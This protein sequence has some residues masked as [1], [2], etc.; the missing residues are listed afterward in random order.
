MFY[1][2]FGKKIRG[3]T[4]LPRRLIDGERLWRSDKLNQVQPEQF[5]AEYANLLPLAL[6]DGTFECDPHRV[7]AQVYAYNR[8]SISARNVEE[9]LNEFERVKLLFRWQ[10]TDKKWWGFWT[11]IK[12]DGLL[13]PASQSQKYKKGKI[14]PEE[15]LNS[16]LS[17]EI[18]DNLDS[19]QT[20]GGLGKA[21]FGF[22]LDREGLG[23]EE[24]MSA[25]KDKIGQL[26]WEHLRV[27]VQPS[28]KSYPELL[29][30]ARII[31]G[32]DKL[33][34]AFE[35]FCQDH[36][37][38]SIAYPLGMFLK[39]LDGY[40]LSASVQTPDKGE[41]K[42]LVNEL[43][44]I[45]EGS[46]IAFDKK[47]QIALG[48]L[49]ETYRPEEI[50]GAFQEFYQ[51]VNDDFDKKHAARKFVETVEQILYTQRKRKEQARKTEETIRQATIQEQQKAE[52]ERREREEVEKEA[53]SL[54][55]DSLPS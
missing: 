18:E 43:A 9:I 6:A 50:R 40:V 54:I 16:F 41:A 38:E 14:P 19:I 31:G 25:F 33:I 27:M 53:E 52:N 29:A 1:S 3:A 30:R 35:T 10:E 42:N 20:S 8:P 4:P 32:Q 48:R 46:G 34:D 7:W 13:P 44:Y 21:G 23:L 5:R 22:G 17:S 2:M 28:D 45:A 39:V 49:L 51:S 12:R 26:A 24:Q 36:A 55:E 47:Q 11:G 15:Q 37:G